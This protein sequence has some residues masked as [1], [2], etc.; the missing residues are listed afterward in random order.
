MYHVWHSSRWISWCNPYGAVEQ[1]KTRLGKTQTAYSATHRNKMISK[2]SL[3]LS[4][5]VL[6]IYNDEKGDDISIVDI[7]ED[8]K[9]DAE[10]YQ[11]RSPLRKSRA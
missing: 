1:I 6:H 3:N 5:H 2:E 10:L 9:E 11:Y 4:E 7:P 8:M